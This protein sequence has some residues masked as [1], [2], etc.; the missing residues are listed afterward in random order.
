V[1][2]TDELLITAEA[3]AGSGGVRLYVVDVPPSPPVQETVREFPEALDTERSACVGKVVTV[4]AS[5]SADV[6][7]RFL[8]VVV[9]E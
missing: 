3:E 8:A 4:S 9:I 5:D 2:T 7:V 6:P 1:N